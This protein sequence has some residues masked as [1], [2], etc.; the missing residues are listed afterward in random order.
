MPNA[1]V[2]I[3]ILEGTVNRLGS[4][5]QGIAKWV[6]YCSDIMR[7]TDRG[8]K[9]WE[10]IELNGIQEADTELGITLGGET[11]AIATGVDIADCLVYGILVRNIGSQAT[12]DVVVGVTASKG[13]F[14][15][16]A[17]AIDMDVSTLNTGYAIVQCKTSDGTIPQ[18]ASWLCAEGLRITESTGE[19]YAF[20]DGNESTQPAASAVDIYVLLKVLTHD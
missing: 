3:P 5:P 6:E 12:E 18:Y 20:C 16:A 2:V 9:F 11:G 1:N 14:A 17:N 13:S 15:F 10:F 7:T 19:L 8:S 4:V